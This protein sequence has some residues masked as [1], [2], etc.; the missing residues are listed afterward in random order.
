MAVLVTGIVSFDIMTPQQSATASI[1]PVV[2]PTYVSATTN[3]SGTEV[4]LT[5]SAP[6]SSTT[7]PA[8][9]FTVLVDGQEVTVSNPVVSGSKVTLTVS[10]AIEKNAGSVSVSYDAPASSAST[11]NLA[12]QDTLGIDAATFGPVLVTNASIVDTRAPRFVAAMTAD[13]LGSAI[14]LLYDETLGTPVPLN[15]AYTVMNG[16]AQV[17]VTSVS[18]VGSK[19][20]LKLASNVDVANTVTVAYLA[21]TVNNSSAVNAAIQDATGNDSATLTAQTVTGPRA[22]EL[23]NGGSSLVASSRDGQVINLKLQTPVADVGSLT[24]SN[25]Q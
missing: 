9:A 22:I 25:T 6:L 5:F 13:A 17:N 19:V 3:S 7:A 8:S 12:V 20:L 21:P 14:S 18:I 24:Q 4:A 16:G 11:S 15:T 1:T 2:L 10:P 23:V